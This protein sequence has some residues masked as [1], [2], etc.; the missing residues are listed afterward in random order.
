VFQKTLSKLDAKLKTL[1]EGLQDKSVLVV[2]MTGRSAHTQHLD[3][4]VFVRIV[5]KLR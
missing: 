1:G 3:G 5:K 4:A 2:A